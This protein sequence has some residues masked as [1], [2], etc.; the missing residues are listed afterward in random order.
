M[1][2]VQNISKTFEVDD[3]QIQALS[4]ISFNV[5]DKEFVTIIGPSGCGK[6]TLLRI[7]AGIMA[8]TSGSLEWEGSP[9]KAFVFQN[10][11]LFPYFTVF[12]NVEFGLK[13]AGVP[14][15]DR[16]KIVGPLIEEVGLKGFEDKHPKELSGGM[17]QRVGI[18]RA[19]AVDPDVILMDEPFSSLDEFTADTLRDLLLQLWHSRKM[20]VIMV[21]HLVREALGLS[22]QIV[23]ME[24]TPG[25][26]KAVI[27]NKLPRPRDARSQPFFNM[28][29]KL[30]ELIKK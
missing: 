23:V 3:S 16:Q 10:Y 11:A 30:T 9:A 8:P 27:D 20:T 19:L 7:I 14:K 15:E 4:D 5:A 13:M 28:E 26:V 29:D 1:L 6:S 21:T 25:R 24:A 2:K 22:D 17:K 12:E 18:A